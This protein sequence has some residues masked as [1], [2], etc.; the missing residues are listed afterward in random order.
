MGYIGLFFYINKH[1]EYLKI[2]VDD[3]EKNGDFINHPMSHFEFGKQLGLYDYGHY[4][5]GRV[6]YNIKKKCFY[7]Y[8]DK[9]L[10]PLVDDIKEIYELKDQKSLIRKDEHYRYDRI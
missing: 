7:L 5:R 3:G 6:I 8:I 2:S 10:E 4:P 9:S 1:I